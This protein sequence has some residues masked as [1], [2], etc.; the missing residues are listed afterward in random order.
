VNVAVTA[1]YAGSGSCP[2]GDSVLNLGTSSLGVLNVALPYG[3]W[4]LKAQIN[5]QTVTDIVTL[6]PTAGDTSLLNGTV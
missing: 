5:G 2:A 1:T 3:N 4:T 6:S